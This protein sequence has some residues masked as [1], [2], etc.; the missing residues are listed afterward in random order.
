MDLERSSVADFRKR[1]GSGTSLE[2]EVPAKAMS[3]PTSA[4]AMLEERRASPRKLRVVHSG[5][6]QR[7]SSSARQVRPA[8][9]PAIPAVTARERTFASA[10]FER[11]GP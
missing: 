4:S 10:S 2:E 11:D 5:G 3:H 1:Y 9:P 8:E 7:A 6:F